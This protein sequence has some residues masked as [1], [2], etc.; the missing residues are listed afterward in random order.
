MINILDVDERGVFSNS[1]V[2]QGT[3]CFQC[4]KEKEVLIRFH[5]KTFI[6]IDCLQ[7]ANEQSK[8]YYQKLDRIMREQ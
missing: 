7:N 8:G 5:E 2:E 6:C 4:A 3:P 1:F